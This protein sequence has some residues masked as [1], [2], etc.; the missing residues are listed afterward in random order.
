MSNFFSQLNGFNEKAIN[1]LNSQETK[2]EEFESFDY[3]DVDYTN[4]IDTD[5]TSAAAG[6]IF[7]QEN[8]FDYGSDLSDGFEKSSDDDMFDF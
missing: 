1:S 4:N 3:S 2:T 5:Y 8:D 6:S 7:G